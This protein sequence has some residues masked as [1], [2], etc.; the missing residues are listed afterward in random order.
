MVRALAEVSP[1]TKTNLHIASRLAQNLA[2]LSKAFDDTE[3]FTDSVELVEL[4]IEFGN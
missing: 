1:A 3:P 4:L 2:A